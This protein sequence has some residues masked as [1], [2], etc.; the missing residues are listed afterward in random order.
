MSKPVKTS[1]WT[2]GHGAGSQ[3]GADSKAIRTREDSRPVTTSAEKAQLAK[4][5][6]ADIAAQQGANAGAQGVIQA[7]PEDMPPPIN[8]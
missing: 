5:K 4:Q 2:K 6:F 3:V 8:R 7:S 1:T